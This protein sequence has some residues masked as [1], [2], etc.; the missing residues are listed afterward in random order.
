MET[1]ATMNNILPAALLGEHVQPWAGDLRLNC[2]GCYCSHVIHWKRG[3]VY[4][5]DRYKD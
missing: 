3:K 2:A 5:L 4:S 1:L